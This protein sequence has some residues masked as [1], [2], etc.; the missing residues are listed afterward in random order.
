MVNGKTSLCLVDSFLAAE[1][2]SQTQGDRRNLTKDTKRND[3]NDEH[4]ER[5]KNQSQPKALK[6]TQQE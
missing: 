4:R 1:D 3:K 2:H 6:S 5:L